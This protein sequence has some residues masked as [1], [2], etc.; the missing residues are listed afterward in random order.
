MVSSH[1]LKTLRL[2]QNG[3]HF[4]DGTF[5]RIFLNEDVRIL[6]KISLKFVPKGPIDNDPALVQIMAWCQ[7]GDKQLSESMIIILLMHICIPRPQWVNQCWLI[8]TL[9]PK[10]KYQWNLNFSEKNAFENVCKMWCQ[11]FGSKWLTF[12]WWH[13]K[14]VIFWLKFS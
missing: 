6:L 7:L 11:H 9:S 1:Y 13:L 12:D 14:L 5:I 4:P 3:H 10:N 8:L 2:R